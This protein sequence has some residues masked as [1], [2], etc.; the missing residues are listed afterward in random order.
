[1]AGNTG[2]L[3]T[4]VTM[5]VN[6]LVALKLGEPLSVTTVVK[7]LVRSEERRVGNE[8]MTPLAE[9]LAL[10]NAIA[11]EFSIRVFWCRLAGMS[12][13]VAVLVTV[14]GVNSAIV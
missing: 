2:A 9:M 4:S 11:M 12:A 1:M 14:K 3:F 10:V 5:T 8:G 7:V 6:V 13:S